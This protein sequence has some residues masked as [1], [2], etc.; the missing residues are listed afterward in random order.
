M[1]SNRAYLTILI[2]V[3]LISFPHSNL[4]CY[5]ENDT[6]AVVNGQ[7]ITGDDFE[8]RFELTVY[9]GKDISDNLYEAK[10]GFLHS[11]V[12]EKLLSNSASMQKTFQGESQVK[13]QMERI[14]LRDAL[15]RKE[16]L[17]KAKIT[18]TEISNGIKLSNYLYVV[19]VF[20]MPDSS[21]AKL[22]YKT[23]TG[24]DSKNIDMVVDSLHIQHDTLQIG[25]GESTEKIEKSFFGNN[26]G[27]ISKPAFTEDGWVV[28]KI[29]HR[30]LNKKY[31]DPT[32]VD[33]EEMVRKVIEERRQIEQGYKYLMSVMKGVD[34]KVN[35]EIFR[36]LVHS[37]K[38]LLSYHSPTTYDPYYYLNSSE[39]V[40]LKEKFNSQLSS[41]MLQFKDGELNLEDVFDQLPLSGFAPKDTSL[42]VI[43]ESLHAALRF[44]AQNHFL[45]QRAIKLG[46]ENSGE[47]KYNVQMFLDAFRSAKLADEIT[48]TV[49]VTSRQVT[50]FFE[51]HKDEVLKEVKLQLQIFRIKNIDEAASQLNRLNK[52]KDNPEDTTG[53]TWVSASRLGELG[54]VLAEL[55]NG[56]TYGPVYMDSTFTIYRVIDKKMSVTKAAVE[57]SIQA[58]RDMLLA[59]TK[60]DVLNKY[61]AKLAEGQNVKLYQNRLSNLQ[62]TPIEMLTFR[63]IGFGGKILAVPALYP[64]EDWVKDY[65]KPENVI[66]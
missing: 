53:S 29:L 30:E 40:L 56:S 19:D 61:V 1:K 2:V 46:L 13:K 37:I 47:V 23:V 42:G 65:K 39:V 25:Y 38:D 57:N 31:T 44:M 14:F 26:T 12:A 35:Y 6:L 32:S 17:P 20:Y 58:A 11:M 54:A 41:P 49:K 3:L 27:F 10:K 43:T 18:K 28:F 50:E 15:Y 22:F 64:R 51:N 33:R 66:P 24:K 16:V 21:A 59:K 52:I 63:Y 34:V 8:N 62:V 36:P 7:P 4:L 60:S 45:E 48:D 5:T 55:K 9:P